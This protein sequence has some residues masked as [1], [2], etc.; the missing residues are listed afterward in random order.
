V[1]KCPNCGIPLSYHLTQISF[2]C[3][4]CNFKSPA[5]S[6]CPNCKGVFLKYKGIGIQ[7]VEEEIKKIINS[8]K[9]LR[10]DSDSI[11]DKNFSE[12]KFEEINIILGTTLSLKSLPF[13]E[14]SLV[15]VINPDISLSLLDFRSAEKTYQ[16]LSNLI[17]KLGNRTEVVI[18]TYFPNHYVI[19]AIKFN[20]YLKFYKKEIKIR[21]EL[22][23]PPFSHLI[24]IMC[25][26][27]D[28][29]YCKNLANK[30]KEIFLKFKKIEILGP[31]NF[32]Y[33]KKKFRYQI[34]LKIKDEETVI[35]SLKEIQKNLKYSEFKNIIVDVDPAEIF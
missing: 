22:N 27:E 18:Q 1:I 5:V 16:L 3:H 4:Y 21:E 10:I 6:S 13:N 30:L 29:E 35:N 9:I 28:E 23:Y 25:L 24:N 32:P 8:E 26:N 2:L 34:L 15:G 33:F 12:I 19:E 7:R 17:N 20:D 31:A 11:S 14:L